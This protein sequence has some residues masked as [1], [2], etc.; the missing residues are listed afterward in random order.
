MS[1]GYGARALIGCR[2]GMLEKPLDGVCFH[3]P[4]KNLSK[5][6]GI[7]VFTPQGNPLDSTEMVAEKSIM[8]LIVSSHSCMD[9]CQ[10]LA[11]MRS[12]WTKRRNEVTSG[13]VD[14]NVGPTSQV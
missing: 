4:V 10:N 6:K 3:K 13:V 8:R 1:A 2:S 5:S 11:V 7:N 12:V 9:P 14:E